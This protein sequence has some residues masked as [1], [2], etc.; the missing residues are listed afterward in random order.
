[1]EFEPLI[2]Y[3]PHPLFSEY[4]DRGV[5]DSI[6]LSA[7]DIFYEAIHFP[8]VKEILDDI[9]KS[10]NLTISSI[11][12]INVLANEHRQN[13]LSSFNRKQSLYDAIYLLVLAQRVGLEFLSEIGST[14]RLAL[15][16]L[17]ERNLCKVPLYFKSL[18]LD[19]LHKASN[20]G[21]LSRDEH[22]R[23]S[24]TLGKLSNA[25][26]SMGALNL[27]VRKKVGVK[28][29]EELISHQINTINRVRALISTLLYFYEVD[30]GEVPAIKDCVSE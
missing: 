17:L 3:E 28:T 26:A 15:S 23:I 20:N 12:E 1:M 21:G 4:L 30:V 11:E 25:I 7:S 29:P 2:K 6:S 24:I 8:E 27:A 9:K 13:A 5:I 16:S 22:K 10:K 19:D 18:Y 14:P